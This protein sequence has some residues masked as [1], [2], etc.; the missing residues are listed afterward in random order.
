MGLTKVKKVMA[1]I[2]GGIEVMVEVC[3]GCDVDYKFGL[4][5]VVP[6]QSEHGMCVWCLVTCSGG[7]SKRGGNTGAFHFWWCSLNIQL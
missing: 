1:V 2:T 3:I 4:R 5:G 7:L 6:V